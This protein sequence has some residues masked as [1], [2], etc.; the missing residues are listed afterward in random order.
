[1][2]K[3][4]RDNIAALSHDHTHRVSRGYELNG[5]WYFELR[6]GGQKGPFDTEES[7]LEVLNGLIQLYERMNQ[8][9]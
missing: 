6:G 2:S 7:M 8:E 3:Q 1:M 4:R 5:Q 9:N